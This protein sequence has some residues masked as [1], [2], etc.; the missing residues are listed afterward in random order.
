MMEGRVLTLIK[1][2]GVPV[3]LWPMTAVPHV[4]QN[5]AVSEID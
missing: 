3:G 2:D 5:F 1:I 4:G